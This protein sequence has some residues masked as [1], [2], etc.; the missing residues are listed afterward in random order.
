MNKEQLCIECTCGSEIMQVNYFPSENEYYVEIQST[1]T[2][3]HT[4]GKRIKIALS[5]I[6]ENEPDVTKFVIGEEDAL[7]LLMFI[8]ST[9]KIHYGI[10]QLKE[11]Y[12]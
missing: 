2:P 9:Q 11:F 12:L 1:R 8:S 3:Y 10:P 7:R 5:Y 4:K 6:F